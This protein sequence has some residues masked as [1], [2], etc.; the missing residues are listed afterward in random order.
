MET[1][2]W[3]WLQTCSAMG[4]ATI[5][6]LPLARSPDF[7]Q[8]SF[9]ASY[10]WAWLGLL[11]HARES[12]QCFLHPLMSQLTTNLLED[13][14]VKQKLPEVWRRKN[15]KIMVRL[16]P[17]VSFAAQFK[18]DFRLVF[19]DWTTL[20]IMQPFWQTR[21]RRPIMIDKFLRCTWHT[22]TADHAFP[23]IRLHV[24]CPVL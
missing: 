17:S 18:N 6:F 15:L 22:R 23:V 13:D 1:E 7:F 16:P 3:C 5:F 8:H 10:P 14:S 12:D 19:L 21:P 11:R 4:L 20:Y 2:C 9:P 24:T